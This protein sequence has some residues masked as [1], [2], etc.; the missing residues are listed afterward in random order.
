[1]D[2][3]LKALNLWATWPSVDDTGNRKAEMEFHFFYHIYNLHVSNQYRTEEKRAPLYI[4]KKT[5]K[6]HTWCQA[7]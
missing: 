5:T 6:S 3:S 7:P 4:K 1:M 2:M